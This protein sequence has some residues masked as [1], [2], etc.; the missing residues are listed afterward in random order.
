LWLCQLSWDE[1]FPDD[2]QETGRRLYQ[3]L[4]A[5][6]NISVPRLVK[7]KGEVT[8]VQI[9]GFLDTSERAVGAF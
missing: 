9:H 4:P 8:N 1:L 2:V 5:L 6:S 7:V 3:Q